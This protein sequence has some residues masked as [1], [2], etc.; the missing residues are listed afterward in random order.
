M[1]VRYSQSC[2][3]VKK[4][5]CLVNIKPF[6]SFRI[7]EQFFFCIPILNHFSLN[8]NLPLWPHFTPRNN[9]Y[10]KLQPDTLCFYTRS[11]FWSSILFQKILLKIFFLYLP[12]W[13]FKIYPSP[14]FAQPY[15]S[16]HDFNKL[17][18]IHCMTMLPPTF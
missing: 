4:S 1:T 2:T 9:G 12:K 8:N 6:F 10:I 16:D 5:I 18:S 17:K 7:C 3:K 11:S 15:L 14:I 13:N